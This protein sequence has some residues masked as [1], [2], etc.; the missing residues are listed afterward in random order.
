MALVSRFRRYR[1]NPMQGP[2]KSPS[3][4]AEIAFIL[5]RYDHGALPKAVQTVIARL[6]LRA[7]R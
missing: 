6:R 4:D 3:A 2:V 5:A 1:K 7:T